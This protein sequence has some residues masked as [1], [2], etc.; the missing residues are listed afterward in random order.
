M[1]AAPNRRPNGFRFKN[2]LYALDASL[3]DR[4]LKLFPWSHY[5]L[6]K[7]AMKLTVGLDLRGNIPA[8]ATVT[9]SKKAD[10]E[11][12]KLLT[13]PKGSIV[14]CGRGYNGYGWYKPLTMQGIYYVTRQ[15]SN[16]TYEVVEQ[17]AVPAK[18]GVT[19][20]SVIRFNSL[21]PQKKQLP[22]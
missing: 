18:S 1:P 2:P 13:L 16:A 20:D 21:R 12:A 8:F 7:G 22:V 19:S 14:V 5:A 11:C 15:R 6:G 10:S 17:R 3:V 4:S 9:E